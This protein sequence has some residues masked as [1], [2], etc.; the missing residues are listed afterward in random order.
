[1]N[2]DALAT[3]NDLKPLIKPEPISWWPPAP[4]WW[5]LAGL[6]LLIIIALLV[7]VWRRWH[8]LRNTAYQREAAQLIDAL[9]A[10]PADQQL[11]LLAEILRRAAVCA[12]GRE[13]AGTESWSNLIQ[14]SY[15]D[16]L[17]RSR[18]KNTRPSLDDSS[19]ELLSNHLYSG[20]SPAETTMQT[21]MAQSKAWLKTLP[22]VER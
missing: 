19:C 2:N 8:Y 1:M 14:F 21:L 12:W 7:F 15:V 16:F 11:P 10:L 9:H 4:G 20:I 13:R 6:L 22:P 18:K 5:L 3:L 17:Q